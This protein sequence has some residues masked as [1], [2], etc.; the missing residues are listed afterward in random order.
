MKGPLILPAGCYALAVHGADA[1]EVLPM[2]QVSD[3]HWLHSDGLTNQL[4][5]SEK[6]S[7]MNI[8]NIL[9]KYLILLFVS[10]YSSQWL[11]PRDPFSQQKVLGV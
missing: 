4:R 2:D 1:R 10:M 7:I 8:M 6:L 9:F 3:L 11:P 5:T